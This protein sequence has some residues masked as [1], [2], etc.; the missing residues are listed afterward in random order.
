MTKF[1]PWSFGCSSKSDAVTIELGWDLAV[2]A[3]LVALALVGLGAGL[4][5]FMHAWNRRH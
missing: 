1:S 5:Y 3:A 2:L 4:E